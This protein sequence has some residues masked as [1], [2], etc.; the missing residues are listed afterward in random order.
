MRLKSHDYFPSKPNAEYI[1]TNSNN[2]ALKF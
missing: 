2:T 1:Y